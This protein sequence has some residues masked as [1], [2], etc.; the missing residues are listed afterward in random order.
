MTGPTP[1]TGWLRRNRW[2]LLA[3]VVVLPGAVAAAMS[4]WTFSYYAGIADRSERIPMGAAGEY[5]AD[6]P[7][8]E[9]A[10]APVPESPPATMRLADY[11]IVPWDTDV[12]GDIGLIEGS[13]A[14]AAL[15]EVD[16]RGVPE[17]AYRCAAILVLPGP[18]GDRIWQTASIL[19]LDYRP[20]GDI[21]DGCALSQGDRFEW[22]AVFVVPEGVGEQAR[23]YITRGA[24]L[25]ERVLRL[26]H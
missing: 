1:A 15:I 12:G 20:S 7:T 21:E 14:V 8:P 13:E 6:R 19:D 17:D 26:E 4:V 3:L 22:E 11:T 10:D 18:D 24:L 16:A 23:L 9:D 5:V 25:P 2:S